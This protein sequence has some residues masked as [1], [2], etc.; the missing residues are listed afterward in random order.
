VLRKGLVAF[1]VLEVAFGLTFACGGFSA[2]EPA[3]VTPGDAAAVDTGVASDAPLADAV[4]LPDAAS[5]CGAFDPKKA[6]APTGNLSSYACDGVSRNLL[7]DPQ[8]CG[9]CGHVC[10]DGASCTNG[11]CQPYSL[12]TGP[13]GASLELERVDDTDVYWADQSRM[14]SAVFRAPNASASNQ[15]AAAMLVEIDAS[16]P[17]GTQV[18]GLAFEPRIYLHT[19]T[20]LLVA[21]FDGGPLSVFSTTSAGNEITPLVRSGPHLFQTGY[22]GTGTFI[23]FLEADGTIVSKQSNITY[24]YDL[25][26]TPDGRYA[27]FIGRKAAPDPTG[28]HAALYRYTVASHDTTPVAVFDAM[29]VTATLLVADDDSVYFPDA[30]GAILRLGVDAP[31]GTPP[32]VLSPG[33]GRTLGGIALDDR[34]VYWFSTT[35]PAKDFF[36]L[37]SIDKCGGGDFKHAAKEAALTYMPRGFRVHGTYLYWAA[38]N[39]IHRLGK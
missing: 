28:M 26:A 2:D 22:T 19:Y 27:F 34:R 13:A 33:N 18:H 21:P 30:T 39:V 6:I 1:G 25:A 9:W 16:E 31:L 8:H 7:G 5:G 14:P 15:S 3:V 4:V 11:V 10:A 38:H 35:L 20:R 23:D 32:S 24:A 12:V 37:W 36:D 17:L 29:D